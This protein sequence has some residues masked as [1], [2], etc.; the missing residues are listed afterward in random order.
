MKRQP[1]QLRAPYAVA[2]GPGGSRL[3][4]LVALS[5]GCALYACED[6]GVVG[7]LSAPTDMGATAGEPP[8]P[9]ASV[10]AP[11]D[12]AANL[13]THEDSDGFESP[14]ALDASLPDLPSEPEN[15]CDGEDCEACSDA[16]SCPDASPPCNDGGCAVCTLDEHC[17]GGE[18]D[19]GQC[20]FW[21]DDDDDD[22]DEDD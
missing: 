21:Y 3:I 12:E 7:E 5:C 14:G 15:D 11:T 18:C 4:V 2:L 6:E 8:P 10:P 22:H 19:G 9:R 16:V 20:S 13:D 17:D 1:G